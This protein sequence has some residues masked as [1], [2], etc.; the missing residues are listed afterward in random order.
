[1]IDDAKWVRL[2]LREE[3]RKFIDALT[4]LNVV[5]A[6]RRLELL[7]DKID[8]E[9]FERGKAVGRNEAKDAS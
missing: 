4:G 6:R 8:E 7:L 9:A 3:A 1:M 2:S 5:P